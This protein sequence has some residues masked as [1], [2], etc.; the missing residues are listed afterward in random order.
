[1]LLD[2][3]DHFNLVRACMDGSRHD[4]ITEVIE[5]DCVRPICDV[6]GLDRQAV[7]SE[8]RSQMLGDS[9]GLAFACCVEDANRFHDSPQNS[10]PRNR[11]P[12]STPKEFVGAI[13]LL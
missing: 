10:G 7:R 8:I 12:L 9:P 13:L 2:E 5:I 3:T 6:P 11:A 4:C 1:M